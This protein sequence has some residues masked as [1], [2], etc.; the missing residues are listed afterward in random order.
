M[1]FALA[2]GMVLGFSLLSAAAEKPRV[3]VSDSKS[4]Q[5][6]GGSGG[7]ADGFG[8]AGGEEI[9]RRQRK[10]SRPLESAVRR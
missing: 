5:V 6:S 7:T 1:K 10:S 4:W 8:G 2:T 9:V 3:Y